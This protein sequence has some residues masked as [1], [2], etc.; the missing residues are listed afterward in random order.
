MA[1]TATVLGG[2][3]Y[4]ASATLPFAKNDLTSDLNGNLSGGA[5]FA[6][7]YYLPLILGWNSQRPHVHPVKQTNNRRGLLQW[8]NLRG[9][10]GLKTRKIRTTSECHSGNCQLPRVP[11]CPGSLQEQVAFASV[12][13]DG[14]C[15]L[16]LRASFF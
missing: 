14:G 5:G 2:G 8:L 12:A 1:S 11:A 9:I 13:R 4:S 3:Q 15:F 7:S 16:E 6:D 10:G